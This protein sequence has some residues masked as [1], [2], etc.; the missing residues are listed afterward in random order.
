MVRTPR[1][2][3][4]SN[5]FWKRT[6]TSCLRL[7]ENP[8]IKPKRIF[9]GWSRRPRPSQRDKI[10]I[11]NTFINCVCPSPPRRKNAFTQSHPP[12][13][14]VHEMLHCQFDLKDNSTICTKCVWT[15]SPPN[16]F[17]LTKIV[18]PIPKNS[19]QILIYVP[20]R[21]FGRPCYT[22]HCTTGLFNAKARELSVTYTYGPSI[23]KRR[24]QRCHHWFNPE[25]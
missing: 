1:P 6:V 24:A 15:K 13:L 3:L 21:S 25:G 22:R 4:K 2:K 5:I 23:F 17:L 8:Q 12:L 11:Q 9:R 7:N 19:L 16:A 14:D 20:T 10:Q 18:N